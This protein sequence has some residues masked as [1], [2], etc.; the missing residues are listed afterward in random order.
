MNSPVVALT[1][2]GG[3]LIAGGSFIT[4]GGSS[5]N[6][7]ARWN[8]S[9][10]SALGAG[11]G[12]EVRALTVYGGELIAGGNFTTA[13]GT[14]AN[15]IARWNGSAWSALGTGMNS[16]VVALTVYGGELIAGGSFTAA[17]GTPASN[18]ARWN[19]S[20]WSALGSGLNNA[21]SALTV[22]G[23][24]LIAGGFFTTAGGRPSPWIAAW[25]PT[26]ATTTVVHSTSP[27]PSLP[28][29]PVTLT[30][31]VSGRVA[32]SPGTVTFI[33]VPSGSCSDLTLTVLDD[34]TSEASCPVTFNL[35]GTQQITARYDGAALPGDFGHLPSVSG[36][37]AHVVA[38]AAQSTTT[39]IASI[40]P[41]PSAVG[42]AVTINATVTGASTRPVDGQVTVSASTG[43][44]C[45]D[46]TPS[47]GGGAVSTFS[48]AIAFATAGPRTLT[49]SFA[50]SSA[51]T[52]SASGPSAHTVNPA[53][54]TTTIVSVTP[55]GSQTVGVPYSVRVQVAGGTTPTGTVT[56]GDGD[57]NT[58]AIALPG[59]TH[60]ALASSVTGA[61]TL[62]AT[63][64][65]DASHSGSA[66]TASYTIVAS[67]GAVAGVQVGSA[68][69]PAT[70]ASPT[71]NP[72]V[73]VTF[74]Q[75]F[76]A[77]PVVIVQPADGDADPQA[78]RIRNV[79]AAGFEVLQVEPPGC[80]GCTGATSSMAVHWLAALPGSYRLPTDGLLPAWFEGAIRGGPSGALLKVGAVSTQA[81]QYNPS[82]PGFGS[83][84]AP[85]WETINWPP[86][87]DGLD[88]ASAPVVL[89]TI[90]SWANEGANLSGAGLVGA[91]QPWA[92]VAARNV[93]SSG[94]EVALD[95]G[96]V[97]ADDTAPP[98]F[99]VPETIGYV[100][101]EAGV[102]Q[103]IEP[104]G[105]GSPVGIATS[106]ATAG[107]P[108]TL[109]DLLFPP[110]TPITPA[111]FRG[112]GSMQSRALPDGGWLR[113]CWLSN[114]SGT[115]VR[116]GL[117]RDADRAFDG[118]SQPLGGPTLDDSGLATLSGDLTTTPVTIA[119]M[120]V[121]RGP[122]GLVLTWST[123]G[124]RAQ[125]G[126]RIWGRNGPRAEWRVLSGLVPSPSPDAV[127]PRF[128]RHVVPA[129][130][131]AGVAE[132]RLEDIDLKGAGRRHPPLAIGE[133]RGETPVAQPIDWAAVR[134]EN[135]AAMSRAAPG[136]ASGAPVVLALVRGDG[137]QRVPVADL[138]AKDARFAG[139]A[140][141]DL[142][143]LDAGQPV[144][145]HVDCVVLV[146]G[147]TIEFYGRARQ[148]R[149]GAEN[150]YALTLD[151][152]RARSAGAGRAAQGSA[153][154][155]VFEDRLLARPNREYSYSVPG[156]DPWY[157]EWLSTSG[158]P[159][160]ISRSFVL[161]ERR[162]GPVRLAVHVWGGLD[163]PGSL[164]DHHVEVRVNGVL[165]S[166][167][168]F[169]GIRSEVIEVEVPEALLSDTNT[170]AVRLPRDTGFSMDAIGFEGFELRWP[171]ASRMAGER[172]AR[173]E[174][175]PSLLDGAGDALY[176]N[177]F[178]AGG[179]GP[180]GFGIAEVPAGS[181]LW[182]VANGRL[183]RDLLA[184]G[185]VVVDGSVEAWHVA[186]PSAIATPSLELPATPYVLPPALDY[187]VIAHPIFVDGLTPLLA[188]QQSRGLSTAVVRTD[189]IFARHSDHVRDPGAI[190]ETIAEARQR[191]ARY[192]L[193]VGGDTLD[194]HDYFGLGSV[195]HVP[196]NYLR[197]D[198]QTFDAPSDFPYADVDRD[199]LPDV[200]V[201]R[202]PV[203]TQAELGHAVASIVQ[204]GA[205]VGGRHLAVAGRSQP[206]ERFGA[207]ARA[208]LSY[209]RQPGQTRSFALA[210]EV[211]TAS[212]RALA[213]E[214]LAG[215]A[216]W[217]SY[218][219]HSSWNRWAFD[220]LLDA[221]SL[222][223]IART[224]LPG[225]VAQW[226]CQTN[227]FVWPTSNT[228]A[229]AL[230]LRPNR[231][232]AA[233]IGSTSL[234]E[235]ASH[236]A[237][238][239]RFYD[240]LEDGRMGDDPGPV[241][242]TIGEALLRAQLDLLVREPSHRPA[243]EAQ[244]LFGDPAM[245][246]VE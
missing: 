238:A 234:V 142:A 239:T 209:L 70:S 6:Y 244:A 18:I 102:S 178:E 17:G 127:A 246:V 204:R 44:S 23:G 97:S 110:A 207:H 146:E 210:D 187:L 58:C 211:G 169:D 81:T 163:F 134:A 116:I 147:C 68:T 36:S 136:R 53:T 93:S 52:A 82:A 43:E 91:S 61:K 229:H 203:R 21:V 20:A 74:P 112:F 177:G 221:S 117:R 157:D 150:A 121:Q 192:V 16:S 125:L 119:E 65:G 182:T 218:L 46:N 88:F 98:G 161:P 164:P 56:V 59:G 151:R 86:L 237:L 153:A 194:Y 51:H 33:G 90:Q 8:G 57:G 104:L 235:D 202:L 165:L 26:T 54:T 79:T 128:Y 31:R 191:G 170:L 22:Y 34:T 198:Q 196:T 159:V 230:M 215:S 149:Y 35:A 190:R 176:A 158:A 19:G 185:D 45:V 39:A 15:Y 101:I 242:R 141:S 60:C 223:G 175:D 76:D 138:L 27:N 184:S 89:T 100:A 5:A 99:G 197:L 173:G 126:F 75:P 63:Y 73:S 236:L 140:A 71:V 103:L 174:I 179:S 224:G 120:S 109:T 243:V 200:A 11:M 222:G 77:I 64:G 10:W 240:L 181:V 9:A 226:S 105:G 189:A 106:R 94:L 7:I 108:C 241:T 129:A 80:P 28:G 172:L 135:S 4:A 14:S 132:V 219:G 195:S 143:L 124:E 38:G 118:A 83:W 47:D 87:G 40:T 205:S 78:L 225:I 114:P 92:T 85:G 214:G 171:R 231:L 24:E 113:R 148:S 1:V 2:Y 201:G 50:G 193:L 37:F 160:E 66:G 233:V 41:A 62:T 107:V 49:A 25:G 131:A 183:A 216:D 111:N 96:E 84:P 12:S 213:R 152:I 115:G 123:A 42:G 188:L 32:P 145:R 95:A 220:N 69:L 167:L 122:E 168:R 67:S 139:A 228:M 166:Q 72:T 162:P 206:H 227:D 3:E 55:P 212:A 186:A 232:A 144:P 156:D 133:R 180:A 245:E 155:Q 30:A 137:V 199:G 154:L 217:I 130:G 48:C 29:Q 13:G 208:M